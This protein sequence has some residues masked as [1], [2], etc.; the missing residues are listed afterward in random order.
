MKTTRELIRKDELKNDDLFD[1]I[2]IDDIFI[3]ENE[4]VYPIRI[5]EEL[6]LESMEENF[7]EKWNKINIPK[8]KWFN[9]HK[10]DLIII[11]C[12]KI[13]SMKDFGKL[14]ILFNF[15]N[16]EVFDESLC[17]IMVIQTYETLLSTYTQET[18]PNFAE[19]TAFL[20]YLLDKRNDGFFLLKEIK[21]S[22]SSPKI[23]N[24]IYWKLL[25]KDKLS[26]I[27]ISYLKNCFIEKCKNN[28]ELKLDDI[29]LLF[30]M[31]NSLSID[32]KKIINEIHNYMIKEEE[33]YNNLQLK[34][35]KEKE[36][37]KNDN[38]KEKK[39]KENKSQLDN[40]RER[41]LERIRT[42][43]IKKNRKRRT[44]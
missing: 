20:I 13:K 40:I 41:M 10:S 15:N 27:L 28:Y 22:I 43:K 25:E 37:F 32:K 35:S 29:S 2:E 11:I 16:N 4:N 17:Q 12:K 7:Y 3:V 5:L 24:D 26:K 42:C 6:N 36:E 18:C 38:K 14:F 8:K 31:N 39:T 19:E 33:L 23:L 44:V 21:K 34:I 9:T 1:L 30:E